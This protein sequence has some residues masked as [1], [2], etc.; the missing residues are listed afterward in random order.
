DAAGEYVLVGHGIRTVSFMKIQVYVLGLYI[1]KDDLSIVQKQ[2]LGELSA[3]I[4][5]PTTITTATS[6][7]REKLRQVL[8][9]EQGEEESIVAMNKLLLPNSD[10][11]AVRSLWRITPTRN[12]DFSHL[13]DG[14]VRQITA[15]LALLRPVPNEVQEEQLSKS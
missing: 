2:L 6:T 4:D 10:G 9:G 1:H 15:R 11:R 5:S 3:A 13:R 8:S 7:E 12:T 14:F